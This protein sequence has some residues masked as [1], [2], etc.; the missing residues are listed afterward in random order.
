[1]RKR[2]TPRSFS[3]VLLGLPKS[4][5]EDDV[6]CEYPTDADDENVTEKGFL[7]ALPGEYTKISSA[8]ALFRGCRILA[9][10][11]NQNYPAATSHELSLQKIS[12]LDQELESWSNDL[13][14]HLKLEFT[15]DKPATGTISSRSPLLV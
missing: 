10:V 1:M 14:P 15:M 2:L 9:K 8:L 5:A 4:I 11:L 3:A 6:F 7:H 13:P 12:E